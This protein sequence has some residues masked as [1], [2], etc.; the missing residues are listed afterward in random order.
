MNFSAGRIIL[1]F[2]FAV[3]FAENI[4]TDLDAVV[5]K[6]IPKE[7]PVIPKEATKAPEPEPPKEQAK[8]P[9]KEPPKEPTK[10]PTRKGIPK[11]S[12][13]PEVTR[14]P[15]VTQQPNQQSVVTQQPLVIQTG[16]VI[17][18]TVTWTST[19]S[20]SVVPVRRNLIGN[21]LGLLK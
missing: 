15:L 16:Q 4:S 14:Q 13:V 1:V 11:I 3:V 10:G 5:G 7:N 12:E 8:E 2:L 6:S 21:I 18:S 9:V 17:P 19:S 20:S